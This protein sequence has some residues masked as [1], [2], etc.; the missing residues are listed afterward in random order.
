MTTPRAAADLARDDLAKAPLGRPTHHVDHYDASLLFAVPRTPQR[1]ALG[2]V[3]ALP[4]TGIDAWTAYE[5]TW[6]DA[7]GKPQ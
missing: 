6:L 4:F 1:A 3:G 2:I 7:S 5:L